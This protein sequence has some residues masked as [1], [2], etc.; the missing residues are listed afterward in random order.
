[1]KKEINV[2]NSWSALD[3]RLQTLAQNMGESMEDYASRTMKL[4]NYWVDEHEIT[5]NEIAKRILGQNIAQR[6]ISNIRNKKTRDAMKMN[7]MRIDLKTITKNAITQDIITDADRP[8]VEV[9]CAFCSRRLHRQ[10]QCETRE[11]AILESNAAS[12]DNTIGCTAC[13]V[14]GHS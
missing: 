7:G 12:I 2:D 9:V 8:D 14:V 5:D 3:N 1:M 6:F 4:Y 10:T 13:N 11:R